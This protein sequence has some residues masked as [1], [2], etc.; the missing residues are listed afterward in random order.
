MK[1]EIIS[2]PKWCAF[3]I[4]ML[5]IVSMVFPVFASEYT[6]K[7]SDPKLSIL[8]YV[9]NF[10]NAYIENWT[11]DDGTKVS[12]YSYEIEYLPTPRS[13]A[14]GNY[15]DYAAWVT[16][17]D[18]ITL[19]LDPKDDVRASSDLKEIAWNCLASTGNGFGTQPDFYNNT[20]ILKWQYDCHYSYANSKDRWN[21]EPWR[22]ASSYLQVV[23]N[24]CNP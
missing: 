6:S 17:S 11:F 2:I 9:N 5:L 4:A 22:T 14:L 8:V 10:D 12:D 15:F 18:G 19:S 7:T 1:K 20:Q 3:V 24:S 16:R 13:Y 23:L 21:L